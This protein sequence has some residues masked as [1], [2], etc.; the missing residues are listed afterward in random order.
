MLAEKV[1]QRTDIPPRLFRELL[2]QA[3]EVV[4]KRLLAQAKPETQAE[5]RTRAGARSPTRSPP[6]RR[7]ATTPPRLRRCGRCIS[8]RKLSEADVIEYAKAGK[9]EETIAALATFARCRS[10]W[11]TG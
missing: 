3:S 8:E 6:R 5:I 4:Q 10:R 1:G 9:Y 7:R 2:M 11:W